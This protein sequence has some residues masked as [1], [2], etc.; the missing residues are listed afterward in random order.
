MTREEAERVK[1]EQEQLRAEQ[2]KAA[3]VARMNAL[4]NSY[5]LAYSFNIG[6]RDPVLLIAVQC[7]VLSLWLLELMT[8]SVGLSVRQN[9]W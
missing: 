1:A 4:L 6:A 2:E 3:A 5:V 9:R 8:R 7:L